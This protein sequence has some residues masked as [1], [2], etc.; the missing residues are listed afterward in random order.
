MRLWTG[1]FAESVEDGRVWVSLEGGLP[2]DLAVA[3]PRPVGPA[4]PGLPADPHGFVPVDAHGRVPG[5]TDVYAAG[6]M[7][8]RAVKQG[9]L[10][11]QQADA[12]AAAIAAA[13]R[14]PVERRP[15]SPC[16]GRCC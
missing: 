16:C 1:A 4:I 7:T 11:T 13:R 6:D 15:T 5:L 3:L 14:V 2:V 10:A 12:A 8:T 9:G